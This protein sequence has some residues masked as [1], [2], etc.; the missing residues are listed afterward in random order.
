[1]RYV[2]AALIIA[3]VPLAGL[4]HTAAAGSAAT[5]PSVSFG[6]DLDPRGDPAAP[7][8]GSIKWVRLSAD[9][10]ALEP[11]RGTFAWTALDAL[12]SRAAEPGGRI[13]VVLMNT[14]KWAALD[15]DAPE[16]VWR[17]QPPRNIADWQRFVGVA[18]T[19]YRGRV[20]AWQVEPLVDFAAFRGTFRD[21]VT[22]LHAARLAIRERD[23]QALVV[24]ASSPGLDLSYV[25]ALFGPPADD[26]DALILSPRGRT[27]EEL[28]EALA[29]IRGRIAVD[30]HH[31][32]WVGDSD[33]QGPAAPPDDAIGD[34][35]VRLAAAGIAGGVAMQFWSGRQTSPRWAP[36][37]DTIIRMLEGTRRV[38]WLPRGAAVY[39]FVA[40]GGAVPVAVMWTTGEDQTVP[41]AADGP[42]RITTGAGE[43]PAPASRDG[44]PTVLVGK[45]PVFVQG[46]GA[47]ALD[48]AGRAAQQGPFQIP[49]DPAHDFSRAE[50]VS[51]TLGPVNSERGLYNQR[52][53]SL[54]A[55]AVVP[56]TVDGMD[57]V[58]TDPAKDAVYV[59][60]DVDHS[61]AYFVDGREDLLVTVE[62]H[63]AK[64]TQQ[65]GFNILYDSMTGY[66]FTPWQW[67]ESGTGWAKYTVRL[68]DA[69]FS[70][71]W[72]WDLAINGAGDKKEPLVIRSI[73]VEKVRRPGP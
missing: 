65:V 21:Y 14:P 67:I 16:V 36:V 2:A 73:I 20:F 40:T 47:A 25:K 9:W 52:F 59:Y 24:A 62:V 66:R 6:I 45:S 19:R 57:A 55:G 12:M 8:R 10:S 3:L 64:A 30:T 27:P 38:G 37:R 58:R 49:R 4:A 68:T 29:V 26:F 46:L 42:L 51:V 56:L 17:H 48:E 23:P 54:P 32:I 72:G 70:S 35:M 13:V 39:A 18:A 22:M 33:A 28:L 43:T 1:M 41:V 44:K 34:Q 63:R 15:Q 11:T 71:A 53:R 7:S 61:F 31:Q 60:L 5:A 69:A 50:N